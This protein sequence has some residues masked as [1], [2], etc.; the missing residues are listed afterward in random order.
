MVLTVGKNLRPD[1]LV[2]LA[3]FHTQV[4]HIKLEVRTKAGFHD[5]FIVI[6]GK[7]FYHVGASIKDAGKAAF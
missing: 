2:E 5:R 6:D 1:F 3:A 4:G 7:E